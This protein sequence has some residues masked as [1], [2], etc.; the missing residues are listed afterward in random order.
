MRSAPSR[1]SR[2]RPPR[3][4]EALGQPDRCEREREE[5]HP[6][7]VADCDGSDDEDVPEGSTGSLDR[8]FEKCRDSS[9]L[10]F[11]EEVE[12]DTLGGIVDR[13]IGEFCDRAGPRARGEVQLEAHAHESEQVEERRKSGCERDA[14]SSVEVRADAELRDEDADADPSLVERKERQHLLLRARARLGCLDDVEELKD[15]HRA[16]NARADGRDQK[17]SK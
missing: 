5:A 17:Q 6:G 4:A 12:E 1:A 9:A 10:R 15:Q 13:A 3:P 14:D 11:W 2:L 7:R 8:S 16:Q